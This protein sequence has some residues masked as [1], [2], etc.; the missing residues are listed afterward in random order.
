MA[1]K[2]KHGGVTWVAVKDRDDNKVRCRACSSVMFVSE[3]WKHKC[4]DIV[5]EDATSQTSSTKNLLK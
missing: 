2:N 5:E 3:W 4:Q 1:R